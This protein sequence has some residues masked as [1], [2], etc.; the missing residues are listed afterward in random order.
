MFGLFKDLKDFIKF[1]KVR[2]DNFSF[3]QFYKGSI[4]LHLG[5]IILIGAKQYFGEPINCHSRDDEVSTF[6]IKRALN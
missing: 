3:R 2:T 1:E 5:A 6:I 4:W